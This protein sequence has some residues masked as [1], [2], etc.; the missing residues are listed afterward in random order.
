MIMMMFAAI[1]NIDTHKEE[2]G[3]EYFPELLNHLT[4]L[5]M[6]GLTDCSA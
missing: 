3:L 5:I 1:I 4:E 6:K 2:I